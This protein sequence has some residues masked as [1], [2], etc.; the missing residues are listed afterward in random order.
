MQMSF[1][2][3]LNIDPDKISNNLVMNLKPKEMNPDTAVFNFQTNKTSLFIF[4]VRPSLRQRSLMKK[5]Q[6]L[7]GL[8]LSLQ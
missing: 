7:F 2:N 1:M 8:I 6:F 5:D 3:K 4:T